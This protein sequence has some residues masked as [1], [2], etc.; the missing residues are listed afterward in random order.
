LGRSLSD[1]NGPVPPINGPPE[2]PVVDT[3]LI[4]ELLNKIITEFDEGQERGEIEIISLTTGGTWQNL[5]TSDKPV[6][7]AIIQNIS[8]E[9]VTI[10]TAEQSTAG[11]GIILNAATLS[12]EGG[13]TLPTGNI[14]LRAFWFVR[15]T[16]GATLA[17]YTE[18]AV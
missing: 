3:S 9:D 6:R 1:P 12:G 14:D 7:K 13:G 5:F 17:V 16:A 15:A 11:E 2:P 8:T 4:E 18:R 10:A